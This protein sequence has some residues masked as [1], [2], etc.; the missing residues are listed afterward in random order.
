VLLQVEHGAH[1]KNGNLW[2]YQLGAN[3]YSIGV[4]EI[5]TYPLCLRLAAPFDSTSAH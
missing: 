2:T 1:R 3:S 4:G 5:L